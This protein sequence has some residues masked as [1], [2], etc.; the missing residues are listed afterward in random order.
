[1]IIYDDYFD[2]LL[3]KEIAT[4]ELKYTPNFK[5]EF[6]HPRKELIFCGILWGE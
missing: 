5:L 1:M 6:K 4:N 3:K 2:K